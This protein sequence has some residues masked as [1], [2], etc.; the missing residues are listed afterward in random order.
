MINRFGRLNERLHE[1]VDQLKGRKEE[2]ENYEDASNEL[3]L[4]DEE[5]SVKFRLGEVFFCTSNEEADNLL[6]RRKEEVVQVLSENESE[7][8]SIRKELRE[9]KVKLYSKFGSSINLEDE[10]LKL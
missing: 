1:L 9:L 2:L 10:S 3:I 6:E 8:E 7:Q 5:D 4:M